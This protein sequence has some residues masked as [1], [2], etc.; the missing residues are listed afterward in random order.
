MTQFGQ[1]PSFNS[2]HFS[3]ANTFNQDHIAAVPITAPGRIIDI[4]TFWDG[5]GISGVVATNVMWKSDGTIAT[6]FPSSAYT[7]SSSGS[8]SIGGQSLHTTTHS[9]FFTANDN[10]FVG[11]FR[12]KGKS[13]VVSVN[14]GG[15]DGFTNTSSANQADVITGHVSF[16]TAYGSAGAG[17]MRAYGDYIPS[18]VYVR[19]SGAWVAIPVDLKRSGIQFPVQVFVRRGGVWTVLN[20][21][22]SGRWDDLIEKKVVVV[23]PDGS[24]ENGICRDEGLVRF[25]NVIDKVHNWLD[26]RLD[27]SI[28]F[29]PKLVLA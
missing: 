16:T 7:T 27:G 6:G 28:K 20:S 23:W 17:A 29:L 14:T 12:D 19:R 24:W 2:F 15:T 11:F 5:D 1:N 22:A 26:P 13:S 21:I 3:G 8:H 10:V 9:V 4:N 18:T 25:G